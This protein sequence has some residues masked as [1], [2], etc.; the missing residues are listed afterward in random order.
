[1]IAIQTCIIAHSRRLPWL[2]STT[3]QWRIADFGNCSSKR[4]YVGTDGSGYNG[5]TGPP[6]YKKAEL[7]QRWLRD[8]PRLCDP[9]NLW[10]SLTTPTAT[11]LDILMDFCSIDPGNVHTKFEVRSFTRCWDNRCTEQIWTVPEYVNDS[12]MFNWLLFG[13]ALW[14][15]QPNL[16][17]VALSVPEII[18]IGFLGRLPSSLGKGR[19]RWSVPPETVFL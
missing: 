5:R 16:K 14:K 15:Y 17:S 4:V 3:N 7:S 19:H 6:H 13:Y 8:A 1:M 9:E 2:H 10:E 11:F 18:A 12:K